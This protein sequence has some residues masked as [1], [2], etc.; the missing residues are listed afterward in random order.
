MSQQESHPIESTIHFRSSGG[1]GEDR[2]EF[3]LDPVRLEL[4]H[5]GRRVELRRQAVQLI[6]VLVRNEG[7]LVT[8][9]TLRQIF[10][11]DQPLE[12]RNGLH[13]CVRDLR[14]AL[15]DDARRPRFVAT[16]ARVG[17]RF[18]GERIGPAA[19]AAPAEAAPAKVRDGF[20]GRLR[21]PTVAFGVGFATAVLLPVCFFLLCV[22]FSG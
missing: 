22:W 13:Q 21:R 17:Y 2:P 18:V 5:H 20:K 9:E 11:G 7:R 3:E 6:A 8:T 14:R 4:R 19:E 10:W 12:W 1:M 16:V 15:S